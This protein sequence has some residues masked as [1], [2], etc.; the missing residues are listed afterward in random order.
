MVQVPQDVAHMAI[1]FDRSCG[2]SLPTFKAQ[3]VSSANSSSSYRSNKPPTKG[4]QQSSTWP[5]KPKCWHCQGDH[6]K[7][8]CP[9]APKQGSPQSTNQ[10]RKSSII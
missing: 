8:D 4:L 7:K 3:Y 5:D 1:D 10:Q 2:Y 9:K 6:F